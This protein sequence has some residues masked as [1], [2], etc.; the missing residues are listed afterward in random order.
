VSDFSE[1]ILIEQP[2]IAMFA[3]LGWQTANCFH[4]FEQGGESPLGCVTKSEVALVPR[5]LPALEKLNLD[6]PSEV[7]DFDIQELI[8]ERRTRDLLLPKLI[9]GELDVSDLDIKTG[10]H[11]Q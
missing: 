2:T 4:E 5:P 7:F 11:M 8:R 1:N 6:L 9:S 3:E 10:G